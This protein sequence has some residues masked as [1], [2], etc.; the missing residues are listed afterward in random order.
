MSVVNCLSSTAGGLVLAVPLCLLMEYLR[1]NSLI[2]VVQ[3]RIFEFPLYSRHPSLSRTNREHRVIV[4]R[5]QRAVSCACECVYSSKRDLWYI[6]CD[7]WTVHDR[8]RRAGTGPSVGRRYIRCER[9][10]VT[11]RTCCVCSRYFIPLICIVVW[12][13]CVRRVQV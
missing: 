2:L 4:S 11:A 6:W 5:V 3:L 1:G 13:A 12:I 10:P 9:L 7:D 8:E